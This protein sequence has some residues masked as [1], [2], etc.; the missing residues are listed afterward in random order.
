MSEVREE[1]EQHEFS[2]IVDCSFCNGSGKTIGHHM[3][4]VCNGRGWF[5]NRER[6]S[7]NEDYGRD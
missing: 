1:E 7:F 3:C 2:H 4:T 6:Q 5:D